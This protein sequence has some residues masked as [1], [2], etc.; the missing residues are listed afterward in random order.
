MGWI[1]E[2]CKTSRSVGYPSDLPALVICIISPVGDE[3]LNLKKNMGRSL[4]YPD[5][6]ADWPLSIKITSSRYLWTRFSA[7]HAKQFNLWS[8]FAS[9]KLTGDQR[10]T[11]TL[12]LRRHFCQE[13]ELRAFLTAAVSH[14]LV[15][16]LQTKP[17][18][19]RQCFSF[20][21]LAVL[22]PPLLA[23]ISCPA[24]CQ[25]ILEQPHLFIYFLNALWHKYCEGH[26]QHGLNQ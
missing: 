8:S 22:P 17:F 15:P 24:E 10:G 13:G 2:Q 14:H 20:W 25:P 4:N 12:Q 23:F 3:H 18:D 11:T 5:F 26:R 21:E 9:A 1:S 16:V 19:T 7:P 6:P